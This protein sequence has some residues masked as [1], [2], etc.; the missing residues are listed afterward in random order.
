M[1]VPAPLL[2]IM[3]MALSAPAAAQTSSARTGPIIES[4]GAVFPVTPDMSTPLDLDYRV[5]FDIAEGSGPDRPSTPIN[6]VARFL[7][8]HAQAGV[9]RERIAAAVVIHGTAVSDVLSE[10]A[11]ARRNG[12]ANPNA[13][14]LRELI[15]AGTRVI[16]CGQS[17]ASRGVGSEELMD[18]VEMAL[19]AM[20][21]FVILQDQG[22]R[23]NP[24]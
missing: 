8:M 19:S 21:A 17:A 6:T 1:R 3:L 14:L 20:T 10:E 23:V 15:D 4:T 9:P 12:G 18:G 11:Y 5:A 16:V 13:T 7:N 2:L 22:Y 24:W